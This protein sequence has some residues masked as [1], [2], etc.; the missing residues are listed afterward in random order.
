MATMDRVP[1]RALV[2]RALHPFRIE[3]DVRYQYMKGSRV[4]LSG[5]GKTLEIS[6]REVRF[7]TQHTL[8]QG[9]IV[10]L[11]VDWPV[12]LDNHCHLKL[13]IRGCV[14]RSEPGWAAIKIERYEFR[15]RA[16]GVM[17]SVDSQV[18]RVAAR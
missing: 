11:A 6:G 14:V 9:E 8:K 4:S 17:V 7:T 5:M 13:E 1:G 2:R 10:R 3:L 15:T 12:V 16:A 18:R